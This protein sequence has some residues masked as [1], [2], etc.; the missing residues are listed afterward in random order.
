MQVNNDN[1][2]GCTLCYTVCPII[3]CIKMVTRTDLYEPNRGVPLVEGWAP[4]LPELQ[5]RSRQNY[6]ACQDGHLTTE[7]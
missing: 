5:L 3:E 2:T 7:I 6:S 1:C 4:R